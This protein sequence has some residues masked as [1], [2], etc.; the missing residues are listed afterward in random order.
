M[1]F[2]ILPAALLALAAA[3]GNPAPP[4]DPHDGMPELS[5]VVKPRL[6]WNVSLVE[7]DEQRRI[8]PARARAASPKG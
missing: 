7:R 4:Q 2:T 8:L 1:L 5:R 3:A 6:Q